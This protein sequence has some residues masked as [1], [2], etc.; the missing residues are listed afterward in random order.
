M[1]GNASSSPTSDDTRFFTAATTSASPTQHTQPQQQIQ[2]GNGPTPVIRSS[3]APTTT[4]ERALPTLRVSRVVWDL[5]VAPG[6]AGLDRQSL[7]RL[8]EVMFPLLALVCRRLMVSSGVGSYCLIADAAGSLCP[9]CVAWI[10]KH[11]RCSDCYPISMVPPP[12]MPPI[13]TNAEETRSM[14]CSCKANGS[15]ASD[16]HTVKHR[17]QVAIKEVSAVG[18]GL[19]C[20][21]HL[22]EARMFL[23]DGGTTNVGTLPALWDGR[24]NDVVIRTTLRDKVREYVRTSC[25]R[26][27]SWNNA[28]ESGCGS[29]NLE[30]VKWLVS[31]LR[32]GKDDAPWILYKKPLRNAMLGGHLGVASWLFDKFDLVKLHPSVL[33]DIVKDCAS[34][35]C[36]SNIKWCFE[37]FPVCKSCVHTDDFQIAL[38]A[39]RNSSVEDCQCLESHIRERGVSREYTFESFQKID[40]AKWVLAIQPVC[41][42]NTILNFL[43]QQFGDVEFTEWLC[44]EKHFVPTQAT[45][46][47]ACSMNRGGP[48]LAKWLSTRV[49]LTQSDMVKSLQCA[50]RNGNIQVAEWLDE[51][52]FIMDAVNS[53]PVIAGTTLVEICNDNTFGMKVEGLQWFIQ[54]LQRP[55]GMK[56]VRDALSTAL[57]KSYSKH[58][59]LLLESFP[60]LKPHAPTTI[61]GTPDT[62]HCGMKTLRHLFS[63]GSSLLTKEFVAHC[64]T[65]SEFYV[66]S[67]K[68]LKWIIRQF[69]LQYSHISSNKNCLLFGLLELRKNMCA[70]W[71]I[72]SFQ[73]PLS[74]VIKMT[75]KWCNPLSGLDVSGWQM[76]V[77]HYPAIDTSVIRQH[78][79]PIVSL[80]PHIALFTIHHYNGITLDELRAYCTQQRVVSPEAR[81]FFGV[82]NRHFNRPTHP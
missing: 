31:F 12:Q 25:G 60:E 16:E 32:I 66:S 67:S 74:D 51:T 48:T 68:M 77:N 61:S 21:S 78:L 41:P 63:V 13:P 6:W 42:S 15:R 54:H 53:D 22:E 70:Q 36:P 71:L 28:L 73:I 34:G 37:K 14:V 76:L 10:V 72:E 62:V 49:S 29:G 33:V 81:V 26:L 1:G 50:L 52:F 58:A 2:Q 23:G 47:G 55:L 20:G 40:V 75:A 45:F 59:N 80:S 7:L 69:D 18:N 82:Y 79:I 4:S 19:V 64:L 39:N 27:G 44:T 17:E 65:E 56:Y 43:C 38:L 57:R 8:A 46:V 35:R 24:G 9:A 11:R 3:L 5:V 30:L